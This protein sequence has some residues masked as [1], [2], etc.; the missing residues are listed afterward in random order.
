MGCGCGSS[1][2][3]FDPL[4]LLLLLYIK[5]REEFDHSVRKLSEYYKYDAENNL[6]IPEIEGIDF[7]ET[8]PPL[9]PPPV[10]QRIVLL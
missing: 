9:L 2:C 6:I 8:S 10:K 4:I 5:E 7:F 1:G 3:D